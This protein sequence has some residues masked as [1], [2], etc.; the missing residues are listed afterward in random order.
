M[1]KLE[2]EYLRNQGIYCI[3]GLWDY[4]GI[5]EKSSIVPVLEIIKNNTYA[6]FICHDAATKEEYEFYLKKW[7]SNKAIHDKYPILYFACHGEEGAI[8]LPQ[9]KKFTLEEL[10]DILKDKCQNKVL[11]FGT[12]STLGAPAKEIKDFIKKTKAL[13]VIGYKTEVDWVRSSA[14]DILNFDA[15]QIFTF[16]KKGVEKMKERITSQIKTLSK[17]LKLEFVIGD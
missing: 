7:H 9:K 4:S 15:M 3:E 11:Y 17:E 5:N 6:K 1:A 8:L 16:D 12:C 10:G 2:E 14:C 13:A